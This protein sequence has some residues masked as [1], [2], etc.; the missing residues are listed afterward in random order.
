[1][2]LPHRIM[3][4]VKS[5]LIYTVALLIIIIVGL[6][7]FQTLF[8]VLWDGN[9]I[10]SSIVIF[11]AIGF[12][13]ALPEK[14]HLDRDGEQMRQFRRDVPDGTYDMKKDAIAFLKSP[15][16]ISDCIAILCLVIAAIVI[17]AAMIMFRII[18]PPALIFILEKPALLLL[19]I[20]ASIILAL[21]YGLFHLI[22]TVQVH[23]D[24]D[25]TRLHLENEKK[26]EFTYKK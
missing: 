12:F 22:F 2:I 17:L 26:M 19:I 7:M 24:W 15:E 21:T 25:E 3:D 16:F 8:F 6:P 1:M 20:P 5:H 13:Y 4:N 14:I 10:L 9:V 23:R 11:L 18:T